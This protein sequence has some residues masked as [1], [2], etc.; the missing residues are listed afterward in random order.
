[1]Q[2]LKQR[3][4]SAVIPDRKAKPGIHAG[5]FTKA[6]NFPDHPR[7]QGVQAKIF[8]TGAAAGAKPGENRASITPDA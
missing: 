1:M 7:S 2:R 5:L 4:I 6:C 3:C 8:T